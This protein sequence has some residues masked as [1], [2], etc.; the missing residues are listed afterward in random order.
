MVRPSGWSLGLCHL[1]EDSRIPGGRGGEVW[2]GLL[3]NASGWTADLLCTSGLQTQHEHN[4]PH[5]LNS[6]YQ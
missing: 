2:K 1:E 5:E 6:P 4:L 3:G